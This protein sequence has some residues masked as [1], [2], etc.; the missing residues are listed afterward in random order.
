[1]TLNPPEFSGMGDPARQALR[2]A[3]FSGEF[4]QAAGPPRRVVMARLSNKTV[5]GSG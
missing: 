4:T 1:M 5:S 3:I 2:D